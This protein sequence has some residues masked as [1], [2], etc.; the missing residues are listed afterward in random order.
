MPANRWIG[1]FSP[2]P[3]RTLLRS[4][5]YKLRP[6]HLEPFQPSVTRRQ[7]DVVRTLVN[8]GDRINP[9][10]WEERPGQIPTI[11]VGGFVPEPQDATYLQRTLF[12]RHGSTYHLLF[13]RRGFSE[14]LFRAQLDDLVEE[15]GLH[16]DAPPVLFAMS[17]GGGLVIDW[18][19]RCREEG[20]HPAI[21]GVVLVSPVACID[22]ILEP[23]AV[24]ATT[25][26]GRVIKGFLEVGASETT[27]ERQE[28]W[29]ERSR[30]VFLKMFES[31]AQNKEALKRVLTKAEGGRVRDGVIRC[32]KDITFVGAYERTDALRRL[33]SLE[34]F[35]RGL[36]PLTHVPVSVLFAE[37][38]TSIMVESSPTR[39]L[40][41]TH[42]SRFFPNGTFAVVENPQGSPVQHASLLFHFF[43]FQ[44]HLRRLY[45]RVRRRLT[46]ERRLRHAMSRMWR[47]AHESHRRRSIAAARTAA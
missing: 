21:S 5:A 25:L 23:G 10:L 33:R 12:T 39:R 46:V 18:L 32:L 4:T 26:L 41:E 2:P 43:D 34:T 22:D 35:P 7:A 6:P 31:G 3:L 27:Q 1:P 36:G 44:P 38:E 47:P 17:F 9:V 19:R 45:A 42:L 29:V 24:K 14:D 8:G 40:F 30:T 13:S 20:R 37:K 28:A 15:L 16:H 11:V